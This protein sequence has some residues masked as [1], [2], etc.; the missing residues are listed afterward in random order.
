MWVLTKIAAGYDKVADFNATKTLVEF[1]AKDPLSWRSVA[2][3]YV[4]MPLAIAYE[5]ALGIP[6]RVAKGGADALRLG[7]GIRKGT[8]LGVFEDGMRVLTLLGPAARL[9]RFASAALVGADASGVQCGLFNSAR[10][11]RLTGTRFFA[12]V[13]SLFSPGIRRGIGFLPRLLD[14]L[15]TGMRPLSPA[16]M[17]ELSMETAG[18]VG[19]EGG[20]TLGHDLAVLQR[21]GMRAGPIVAGALSEAEIAE[22]T[23]RGVVTFR[24]GWARGGGHFMLAYRDLFGRL[25][26]VDPTTAQE[27]GS[28]TEV[29]LKAGMPT[30]YQITAFAL[31]EQA[32]VLK[33]LSTLSAT[34]SLWSMIAPEI[35]V[36]V[37]EI[38]SE[39]EGQLH[40]LG[41]PES[42]HIRAPASPR[43]KAPST[44]TPAPAS[45]PGKAPSTPKGPKS[46]K[47]PPRSMPA[48][49]PS[50]PT[51]IIQG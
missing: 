20:S 15:G 42:Y 33:D 43:G 18:E 48:V 9:G 19:A 30:E 3:V 47:A 36:A 22:Q 17:A 39:T 1:M 7:D 14:R 49:P 40:I 51:P 13:H 24:V 32:T 45:P 26:Y 6:L 21:L 41:T 23:G 4:G 8:A 5:S 2:G 29:L 28:L 25:R 11:A 31:L 34:S 16:R 44:P 35:K 27:A 10:A 46:P 38:L 50:P 37:L 12:S